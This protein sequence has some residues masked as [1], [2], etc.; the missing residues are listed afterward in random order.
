M[1]PAAAL[2]W[3]AREGTTV[4]D[5]AGRA[6]G[7]FA[8]I[9]AMKKLRHGRGVRRRHGWRGGDMIGTGL[10]NDEWRPAGQRVLVRH[11]AP[12][13][14]P[15]TSPRWRT[16]PTARATDQQSRNCLVVRA[17]WGPCARMTCD[18]G[19]TV[20]SGVAKPFR[21]NVLQLSFSRNF[22]TEVDQVI[23][24]KVVDQTTLYNFYKGRIGFSQPSV[25]KMHAN[26]AI[27][28]ALVNSN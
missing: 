13:R 11:V 22:S 15:C 1:A 4:Q 26:L 23:N 18:A 7:R 25:H 10:A 5:I 28:W 8:H 9:S 12:T 17:L 16:V 27:F 14:G 24:R 2:L 21:L 6:E 20:R 19:T 3:L